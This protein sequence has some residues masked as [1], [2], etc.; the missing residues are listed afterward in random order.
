MCRRRPGRLGVLNAED[1]EAYLPLVRSAQAQGKVVAVTADIGV[2]ARGL[3]PAAVRVVAARSGQGG[4]LAEF[5]AIR[6][7]A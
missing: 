6:V 4:R 7:T 2:T 5:P 3:P 1:A